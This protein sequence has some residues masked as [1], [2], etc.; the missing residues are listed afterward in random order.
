MSSLSQYFIG[1]RSSVWAPR[2]TSESSKL[3]QVTS[4]LFVPEKAKSYRRVQLWLACYQQ[5]VQQWVRFDPQ[6]RDRLNRLVVV[7]ASRHL[8]LYTLS[9]PRCQFQSKGNI[10]AF[11]RPVFVLW[12]TEL[13]TLTVGWS[14]Q[15]LVNRFKGTQ[16]WYWSLGEQVVL[17]GLLGAVDYIIGHIYTHP[18]RP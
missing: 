4:P 12:N 2:G 1:K 13:I 14:Y 15:D 5:H 7:W 6:P 18:L 10:R 11:Q 9:I 17:V 16:D 3:E 8:L